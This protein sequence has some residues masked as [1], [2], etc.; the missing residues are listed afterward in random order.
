MEAL[1][2]GQGSGIGDRGRGLWVALALVLLIRLP[3]LNQAIQ[4]DDHTYISEAAHALVEPLHPMH[5]KTVFL[6]DEIDL[7]GHAHPPLN[8]W[9]LAGLIAIFGEVREV[10][11]HAVYMAFSLVAVWA[12]WSLARRFSR[13]PLWATLLF[14]AVPAFV[15]NGNSLETDLPFLTFWMAAIALFCAGRVGWSCVPMA[16]AALTSYQA[17]LLTPCWARIGGSSSASLAPRRGAGGCA[18]QP[19]GWRC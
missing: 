3:F 16:L 18:C 11:F 5:L 4:G 15:V 13:Q 14:V 9:V 6:G 19:S 17:V 1:N 10:P 7:R 8:A 2:R 12:M